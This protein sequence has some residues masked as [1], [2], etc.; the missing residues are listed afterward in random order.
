MFTRIK[1]A[2][3]IVPQRWS[4]FLRRARQSGPQRRSRSAPLCVQQLET[5]LTPSL[6]ALA[7]FNGANGATPYAPL[8][9]DNS[10]NFYGTTVSGGPS[11][12]G[13][14]F[15]MAHGSGTITRLA[16]FNGTNGIGPYAAL[17]MDKSGNLYGTASQ[18][19]A[20]G[21]GTV[22]ELA[23]G[24][25]T[26]TT[27]ASFNGAN[28]QNPVGA[29]IMDNSGN[30]YGTAQYGG[31]KGDGT[32]FELAHGASTI[33]ALDS[34]N[35]TNGQYPAGALIMDSS[36]N[37]YG[38]TSWGGYG[39][40][41]VFELA[42]GV[43]TITTLA[44]FNYS[45]GSD[46]QS[47]LIMDS[48]GNLYGTTYWGGNPNGLGWGEVFEL[49]HGAD[50]I[51]VLAPFRGDRAHPSSA[52]IMDSSGNLYGTASQ[53]GTNGQ[54]TVFEL[55]HGSGGI[56]TLASFNG[57]NGQ[58]PAGALI[59]DSS[60][61]LYGTASKGGA[62]GKG[63]VFELVQ[64][65]QVAGFPSTTKAGVTHKLTVTAHNA[66]GTIDIAYQGTVS[67]TSSD[68]QA[69]LPQAYTF[70]AADAGVHTFSATL[71]TA[72]SQYVSVADTALSELTGTQSGITVSPAAL[73]KLAVTGFPSQ[74]VAGVRHKFTVTVMDRFGNT[75][76]TYMGTVTFTS[77]DK[78]AV[79]PDPYTFTAADAG[80]HT[81]SAT[82]D[83]A[84]SESVS[85]TDTA[86]AALKGTQAGI[87]VNP[88]VPSSLVVTG[89]PSSTAAGVPHKFTVTAEDRFGNTVP[90]YLG[91]VTFTSSDKQAVLP[92]PY[93]FTSVDGGTHTFSAT[94]KTVVNGGRA[95]V[96]TDTKKIWGKEAGIQVTPA[97]AATLIVTGYPSPDTAGAGHCFTVK[98]CDAY[99]NTATGYTGT[100]QFSSTDIKAVLPEAYTFTAS[101]AGVHHYFVA[102][103]KTAGMQSITAQDTVARRITGTQASIK[104]NP[105]AARH[106]QVSAPAGVTAGTAFTL[107]VTAFDPF[108]NVATGYTGTVHCTSSDPKAALPGSYTFT[109][110]DA[111]TH[112][113]QGGATL[114]TVGK[115][116][117]TATDTITGTIQG[118]APVTV[119]P[120][121]APMSVS[122]SAFVAS[123]I[124]LTNLYGGWNAVSVISNQSASAP[125]TGLGTAS[126]DQLMALD[127][128][129][130]RSKPELRTDW[131]WD[132]EEPRDL[133]PKLYGA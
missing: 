2:S 46:P 62:S 35:Y 89:F 130:A 71:D 23:H 8:I 42:H 87:T 41:T 79:L 125:P 47:A 106:L 93:T 122:P 20:S 108:G 88:A 64:A 98:A 112:A 128:G 48:G 27:L 16:S 21:Y 104:I 49:A 132:K 86:L 82:L 83:T 68:G 84:G 102:V 78:Q 3:S 11:N 94:L 34:F 5:R 60:G 131:A 121:P 105:A 126:I 118:V 65:F 31:A 39:Y 6:F 117:I 129:S 97:A 127:Y 123:G 96:A 72:G 101:D 50:T 19:G 70:T 92:D 52:L 85:V 53:G 36:G 26:I 116:T 44:C 113:F 59:M 95:I 120:G 22:F 119:N 18:G 37:F 45:N 76:P 111:G 14:V 124:P 57:A 24:S 55:A 13:T 81:F 67:F 40:G 32:V 73:S 28:G 29:L 103:L 66:D 69:M 9:M 99:G 58:N 100:V 33:T 115:K 107:A 43:D 12:Y 133:W 17:I 30:L 61:N 7:S 51:T 15:E 25:H 77:S 54:G 109:S 90:T 114:S 74:T 80:V 56:T 1:T 75:V 91:T 38:T 110:T 4:S 10:G 63:T